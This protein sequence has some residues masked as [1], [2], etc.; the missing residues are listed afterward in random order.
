MELKKFAELEKFAVLE[1]QVTHLLEAF[2]RVKAENRRLGQ[3]VSQ[4]QQALQAQ[5]TLEH[6]QPEQEELRRLHTMLHALQREREMMREKL[7]EM[8]VTIAQLEG[9][10]PMVDDSTA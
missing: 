6:A 3:Q 7:E 10:S 4:L 1:A 5:Q 2:V 8:L 9:L